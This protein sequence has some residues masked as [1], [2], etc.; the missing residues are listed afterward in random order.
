VSS[1]LNARGAQTIDEGVSRVAA[2]IGD[3]SRARMLCCLMDG[4]ART[5]TELAIVAEIS[6]ST[7]S[8]HLGRLA[9]EKLV[10]V[11]PQ[12]KHRYYTLNGPDVGLTM[13]NLLVLSGASNDEFIPN[14]PHRL[15]AARTC[16]DHIAGALGV[17]LHDRILKLDWLAADT[18]RDRAYLL[19]PLG[20]KRFG[21]LG[22]ELSTTKTC[23]RRFA[24][25]CIDWSERRPHLG[26]A[27]GA[28]LLTFA[29][30]R[31]WV[32]PDLDSRALA[33]SQRGRREIQQYFGIA[34]DQQ[35]IKNGCTE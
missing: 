33:V 6:P 32:A 23:R 30:N 26:G 12:G 24:F 9:E 19:T 31:K 35:E 20:Q 22:I 4:H 1:V 2:A 21:E 34:L 17:A 27:V 25:A 7:A 10:R 16:Y 28:A 11:V 15:R 8:V 29:L 3:P 13:E 5:A 14:T 18:S